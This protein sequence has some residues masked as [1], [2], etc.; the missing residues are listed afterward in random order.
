MT[1]QVGVVSDLE[2]DMRWREWQARGALTDRR[3]GIR[4]RAVM[5]ILLAALVLWFGFVTVLT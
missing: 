2:G 5:L 1:D 4:M 3:M